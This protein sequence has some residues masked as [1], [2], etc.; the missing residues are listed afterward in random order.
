MTLRLR[1][2]HTN[3]DAEEHHGERDETEEAGG[4][5]TRA[6]Q[7]VGK[8][9]PADASDRSNKG[10]SQ[11]AEAGDLDRATKQ[12][13]RVRLDT[14]VKDARDFSRQA[15]SN[16]RTLSVAG[17][18]VVWLLASEDLQ[19]LKTKSISLAL[20]S[21]VLVMAADL[22]H[23]VHSSKR[24]IAFIDEQ[25]TAGHGLNSLVTLTAEATSP[26]VLWF[27]AKIMLLLVAYGV[28]I[29]AFADRVL[30]GPGPNVC[31]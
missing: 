19:N 8:H 14:V 9:G 11:E 23:Y 10:G 25:T 7:E 6:A 27:R 28:L 18:A 26:A 30:L 24:L 13:Q 12:A 2:G 1:E 20:L 21:F 16:I 15:S 5:A 31:L 22:A 17:F 29:W 4:E 3:G